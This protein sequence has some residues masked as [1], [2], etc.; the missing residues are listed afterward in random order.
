MFESKRTPLVSF[1]KFVYRSLRFIS[2]ALVMLFV[3]L[4]IGV[5][6]YM[7]FGSLKIY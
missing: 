5:G 4:G 2:Y 3:S 6:G 1:E 7:Y